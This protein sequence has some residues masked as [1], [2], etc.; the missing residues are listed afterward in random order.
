MDYNGSIGARIKSLRLQHKMTLKHLSENSGL[1]IGFLSQLERGLS[2]IAIDS[3]AELA[4]IFDVSL[5][6]FFQEVGRSNPDPVVRS[7]DQRYSWVSPQII[8]HFLFGEP[9]SPNILP[10]IYTLFPIANARSKPVES[11]CHEGEEFIYVLEGIVEVMVDSALYTLYPGDSIMVDSTVPHNWMNPT[12]QVARI[13]TINCPNPL[14]GGGPES[15]T[16]H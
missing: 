6:S 3:L 8:Q 11:Y 13:L 12:N 16:V 4:A 14:Y 9:A 2:S 15:A 7:F 10:R 1:S 5:S